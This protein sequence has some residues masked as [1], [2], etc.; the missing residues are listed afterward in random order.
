MTHA[1]AT[2]LRTRE[3]LDDWGEVVESRLVEPAD[4]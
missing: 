4:A 3:L 1:G 2:G